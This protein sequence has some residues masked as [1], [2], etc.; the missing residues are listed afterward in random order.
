MS[1]YIDTLLEHLS[2]QTCELGG[3]KYAIQQQ[4]QL[5]AQEAL[6]STLTDEQQ[7]LLLA[8]EEECSACSAIRGDAYARAAFLLAREIYR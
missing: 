8:Y 2:N 4:R 6:V 5:L 3:W 1:D 7:A